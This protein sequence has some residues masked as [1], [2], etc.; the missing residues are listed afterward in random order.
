MYKNPAKD[1]HLRIMSLLAP[2]LLK[3]QQEFIVITDA[4]TDFGA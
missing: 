4:C 2:S 3:F 1:H